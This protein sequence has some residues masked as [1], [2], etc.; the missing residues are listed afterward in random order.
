MARVALRIAAMLVTAGGALALIP[1]AFAEGSSASDAAPNAPTA[2]DCRIPVPTSGATP[3]AGDASVTIPIHVTVRGGSL[4]LSTDE[5]DVPLTAVSAHELA[6][7]FEHV[8][9][10]DARGTYAGWTL[11]GTVIDTDVDGRSVEARVRVIPDDAIAI[12]GFADGLVNSGDQAADDGVVVAS[13]VAG[14]GAGIYEVSGTVR[15]ELPADVH[16]EAGTLR[17]GLHLD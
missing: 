6:G 17:L 1:A 11:R 15:V 10:L 7:R 5:V 4:Q 2:A 12:D 13:A 8:R 16:P 14:C 3:S 9:L